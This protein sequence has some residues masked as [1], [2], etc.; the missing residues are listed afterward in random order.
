MFVH[1]VVLALPCNAITPLINRCGLLLHNAHAQGQPNASNLRRCVGPPFGGAFTQVEALFERVLGEQ[2][3]VDVLV[4][5]CWGGNELPINTDPFWKQG[6]GPWKGMFE[7]GRY[8]GQR[9]AAGWGVTC[10]G[11]N[12]G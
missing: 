1:E 7:A 4:N 9:W 6:T 5:A 10:D 11:V 12:W 2:G 8:D 3:R